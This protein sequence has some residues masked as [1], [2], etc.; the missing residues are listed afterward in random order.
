ME[1]ADLEIPAW[2]V[3]LAVMVC[4]TILINLTT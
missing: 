4:S 1:I 3:G 2:I